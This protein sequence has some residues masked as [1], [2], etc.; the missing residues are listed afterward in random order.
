MSQNT[1]LSFFASPPGECLWLRGRQ[2]G[3][4]AP[5]LG[6]EPLLRRVQED[7]SP[8]RRLR[9][10]DHP[11]TGSS[12]QNHRVP[13]E[14]SLGFSCSVQVFSRGGAGGGLHSHRHQPAPVLASFETKKI[15]SVTFFF[16][17][18]PLVV[19]RKFPATQDFDWS[20]Q[21]EVSGQRRLE[22][23]R[24]RKMLL[25]SLSEPVRRTQPCHFTYNCRSEL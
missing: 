5:L 12:R 4:L 22:K 3:E 14:I 2:P 11:A 15:T 25:Q 13:W 21:F 8:R 6:A 19:A 24:S 18:L 1:T 23:E 16:L 9:G 17:F 10:A 20:V 7:R